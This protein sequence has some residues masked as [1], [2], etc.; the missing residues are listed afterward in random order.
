L[1]AGATVV[2][3][4]GANITLKVGGNSVV[5]DPVG[6]TLKGNL[7]VIDGQ[8]VMIASGPGSPAMS[9]SAGSLVPP[10]APKAAEEA[11]QADPGEVNKVKAEQQRSG[12]GK[13]GAPDTTP[14]NPTKAALQQAA[15]GGGAVEQQPKKNWIEVKLVNKEGR[16]VPGEP[17][18]VTFQG[19]VVAEGTLDENGFARIDNLENPGQCKVTFPSRDRRSWKPKG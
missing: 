19:N 11:D 18:R 17:Y 8:M 13:Y 9:G 14:H 4:A 1:K 3:E 16:P 6:V 5:I 7:V 15:A 10:A 2:I 12:T